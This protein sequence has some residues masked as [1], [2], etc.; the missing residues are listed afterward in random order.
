MHVKR[1]QQIL[2]EVDFS[3]FFAVFVLFVVQG[4]GKSGPR[5]LH[6]QLKET[7]ILKKKKV[8]ALKTL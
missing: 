4:N 8:L 5:L 7:I 6:A 1:A 2:I 3:G